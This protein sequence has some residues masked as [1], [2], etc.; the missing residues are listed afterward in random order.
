MILAICGTAALGLGA[1]NGTEVPDGF[2]EAEAG[3]ARF[4]HP[5]DWTELDEAGRVEGA[6]AQIEAPS[7]EGATPAGILVFTEP[8]TGAEFE[9]LV[10]NAKTSYSDSFPDFEMVEET[11]IDVAGAEETVLLEYTY[12]TDTG[13]TARSYDVLTTS[14]DDE[15]VFRV[16]GPEDSLDDGLARQIIDTLTFE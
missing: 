13:E 15:T 14:D 12:S 11:D 1:C 7:G 6:D 16:A 2:V 4:A 5:E 3:P 9:G 8:A 10:R